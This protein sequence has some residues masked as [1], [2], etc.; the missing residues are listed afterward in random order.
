MAVLQSLIG[1]KSN[2]V[3]HMRGLKSMVRLKGGLDALGM[4]G[5]LRRLVLWYTPP[6]STTCIRLHTLANKY[7]ADLCLSTRWNTRP[8][9]APLTF[10]LQSLSFSLPATVP[11]SM[12]CLNDPLISTAIM[13]NLSNLLP[14]LQDLHEL[15]LFLDSTDPKD[16][17]ILHEVAYADRSYLVEHKAL[18]LIAQLQ[19]SSYHPTETGEDLILPLLLQTLLLYIYTNI[20]LTPVGSS[21]R[22]ALVSRIK[23]NI[24]SFQHYSLMSL[25]HIFPHE[26]LWIFFL[27]GSAA[28]N[29]EERTYFVQNLAWICEARGMNDWNDI[30]AALGSLLWLHKACLGRCRELCGDVSLYQSMSRNWGLA[31]E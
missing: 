17:E 14:L 15:S 12:L 25:I 5:T 23:S 13:S 10:P 4:N 8:V 21:L 26:M 3:I 27:A 18:T 22:S 2:A 6:T 19:S 29:E 9:F 1:D 31:M 11:S 7:R 30:S 28:L 24:S 16:V 20:R